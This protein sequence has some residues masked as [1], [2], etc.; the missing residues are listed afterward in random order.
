MPHPGRQCHLTDSG[1]LKGSALNDLKVGREP[2]LREFRTVQ[3]RIFGDRENIIRELHGA[4]PA[5]TERLLPDFPQSCG[6]LDPGE[7]RTAVKGKSLNDRYRPGHLADPRP[8]RRAPDQLRLISGQQKSI[9]RGEVPIL[10]GNL[11][12]FQSAAPAEGVRGQDPQPGGKPD[13]C[14]ARAAVKGMV[15][16]GGQVLRK[17]HFCELRAL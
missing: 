2:D 1:A 10:R 15:R 17:L 13:L 16:N 5:F 6:K 11:K 14:Q 9:H 4:Q 8:A 7:L 12:I 3:E